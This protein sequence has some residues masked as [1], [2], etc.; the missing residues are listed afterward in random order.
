MC[1]RD[2]GAVARFKVTGTGRIRRRQQNR[3]HL[4]EHKNSV[5]T[6]RLAG[7]V[8]VSKSDAKKVRRMLGL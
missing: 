5:R 8:E 4:L 2:R 7:E 3:K 6:R 1:I